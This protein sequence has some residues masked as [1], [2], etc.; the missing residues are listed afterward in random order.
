MEGGQDSC[1]ASRMKTEVIKDRTKKKSC[2]RNCWM[3]P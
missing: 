3:K 1:G 2:Q